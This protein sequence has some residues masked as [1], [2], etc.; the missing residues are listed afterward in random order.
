M[1]IVGVHCPECDMVTPCYQ[2]ITEEGVEYLDLNGGPLTETV[3]D[4]DCVFNAV[5]ACKGKELR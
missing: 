5:M 3:H 4:W 2:L 1:K